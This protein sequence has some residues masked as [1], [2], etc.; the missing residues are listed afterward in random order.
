MSAS[1]R[2]VAA[3]ALLSGLPVAAAAQAVR[4]TIVDQ[5]GLPLPG[6]IVELMDGATVTALVVSGPDGGFEFSD[7]QTGSSIR[8]ALAGFEAVIVPRSQANRV[9]LPIARASETTDVTAPILS[10][11][12]PVA[13]L[14]DSIGCTAPQVPLAYRLEYRSLPARQ[15]TI[16]ALAS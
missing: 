10:S 14:L 13:P 16:A 9:V 5:T 2:V 1:L 6:A 11:E 4:G 12:S 3:I 8:V 7:D 15:E